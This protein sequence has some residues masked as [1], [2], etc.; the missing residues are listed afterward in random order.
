MEIEISTSDP[1]AV[2]PKEIAHLIELGGFY[3]ASVSINDG[4][5]RWEA[6]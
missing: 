5:R 2:D 4:E 3:V 1:E 6:P